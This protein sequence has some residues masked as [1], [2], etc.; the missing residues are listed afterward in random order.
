MI[1]VAA[2]PENGCTCLNFTL[3]LLAKIYCDAHC[4]HLDEAK[5]KIRNIFF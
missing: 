3:I 4:N 5:S 2:Q 1:S